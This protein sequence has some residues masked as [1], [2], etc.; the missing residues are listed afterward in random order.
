MQAMSEVLISRHVE[1]EG[2]GYL[3]DF[4]DTRKIPYHVVKLDQ[5]EPL[6]KSIDRISGL[7]L[8]GGPMSVND[9]LPWIPET[10]SLIR[11]AL[12][13]D[14]PVLGHCLG[15]QLICKAMNGSVKRSSVR[16]IGWHPVTALENPAARAWFNGLPPEF[17]AFHWHG[18]TFSIPAGAT[19]ILQSRDCI[20][21][22]FAIDGT[23][24]MQ[25]HV[26]MTTAMVESWA[27]AAGKELDDASPTVQTAEAMTADLRTRVPKLQ[28]IAE[29]IYH[30]WIEGLK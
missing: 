21:Q 28:S 8:M 9:N 16:E 17:E 10:I 22:A 14:V 26:E 18:E 25:C 2:P 27:Q 23:L 3:A 6:P 7:V 13:A 19:R 1:N 4:L 5:N 24:A 20:N 12:D 11:K 30:R 15:G 29:R